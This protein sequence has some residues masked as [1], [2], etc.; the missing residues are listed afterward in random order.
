M[1][2][3][4]KVFPAHTSWAFV[5][6]LGIFGMALAGGL[7]SYPAYAPD[8]DSPSTPYARAAST[9]N[10]G[11]RLAE[12]NSA[13]NQSMAWE[14]AGFKASQINALD[15]RIAKDLDRFAAEL[16]AAHVQPG[17]TEAQTELLKRIQ[18]DFAGYQKTA[19]EALDIK[20]GMLGNAASF[21]TVID[22]RYA[23][24]SSHL[25]Q[26][27]ELQ[28]TLQAASVEQGKTLAQRYWQGLAGIAL[29]A[30]SAGILWLGR[31]ISTT[32]VRK[33][34]QSESTPH[35]GDERACA[36]RVVGRMSCAADEDRSER[37]SRIIEDLR[38]VKQSIDR[39]TGD[40][41]P[42]AKATPLGQPNA[43]T[44]G[45]VLDETTGQ[46]QGLGALVSQTCRLVDQGTPAISA[47]VQEMRSIDDRAQT[48]EQKI[49]VFD[50]IAFRTSVLALSVASNDP[51]QPGGKPKDQAAIAQ[52]WLNL[53]QSGRDAAQEIRGLF[54]NL[55][56]QVQ[57]GT[58]HAQAAG[59]A[60]TRIAGSVRQVHTALQQL[61]QVVS[62]DRAAA[63]KSGRRSNKRARAAS[64]P[65]P[66]W[67]SQYQWSVR[68][69]KNKTN[70]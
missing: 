5:V 60:M 53:A 64:Q 38:N 8:N 58:A 68:H 29:I 48:I 18:A 36:H 45:E 39:T 66:W 4:S 52:E 34:P 35:L 26:L 32:L 28:R 43:A 33:S 30:A 25:D 31:W 40:S 9:E 54:N 7:V 42:R 11:Q 63:G 6:F 1:S 59:D 2:L 51:A 19:L 12:L 27:H 61:P 23:Q 55:M 24:I 62:G 16:Q 41:P 14:G 20:S 3:L 57:Y 15:R 67:S 10:L 69:S 21:M 47:I 37:L 65:T 46:T 22:A 13:I 56:S 44:T 49:G 50:L 17:L 70:N